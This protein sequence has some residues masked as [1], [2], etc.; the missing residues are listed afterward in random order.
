MQEF[1]EPRRLRLITNMSGIRSKEKRRQMARGLEDVVEGG[2]LVAVNQ[3][4][5]FRLLCLVLFC[6]ARHTMCVFRHKAQDRVSEKF[7]PIFFC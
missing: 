2:H 7:W 4:S 5:S 1:S 6:F 3:L